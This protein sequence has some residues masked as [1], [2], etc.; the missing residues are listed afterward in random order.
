MRLPRMAMAPSAMGGEDIGRTT[1]ARRSRE[2]VRRVARAGGGSR[3]GM[4]MGR[5]ARCA[6][7][8]ARTTHISDSCRLRLVREASVWLRALYLL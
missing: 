8:G 6:L 2:E 5:I 4:A 3:R 1:R 7:D